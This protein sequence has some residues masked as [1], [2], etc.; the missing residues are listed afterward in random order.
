MN[1]IQSIAK[2]L[3]EVRKQ[4]GY[5]GFRDAYVKRMAFEE[6]T[7]DERYDLD[8]GLAHLI[9]IELQRSNCMPPATDVSQPAVKQSESNLRQAVED[10][11]LDVE[12][13]L[14][15]ELDHHTRA[16]VVDGWTN[17][18]RAAA[19][20]FVKG[21]LEHNPKRD[22]NKHWLKV[23]FSR[24]QKAERIDLN[25]Y[26]FGEDY[27]RKYPNVLKEV[28]KMTTEYNQQNPEQD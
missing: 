24:E 15:Y 28:E 13:E 12:A 19:L 16:S 26:A 21:G 6:L 17:L 11:F 4:S 5:A 10:A 1:K 8:L 23:A 9:D 25:H 27:L 22:P 18:V 2:E 14:N 7:E 20:K 3:F